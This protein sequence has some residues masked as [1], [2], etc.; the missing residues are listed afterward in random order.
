MLY[1]CNVK[2]LL[3]GFVYRYDFKGIIDYIFYSK[4]HMNLIGMLGPLEEEWFRQNKVLGCPHPHVPSDHFPLLVEFEM[5]ARSLP[6]SQGT[7][8]LVQY[9]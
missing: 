2:I 5:P 7:P 4:D 8:P 3:C 6:G 1:T 9:R